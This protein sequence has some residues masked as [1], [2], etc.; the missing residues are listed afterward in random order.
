MKTRLS[1]D[2]Y[3]CLAL[4]LLLFVSY[5]A[6]SVLSHLLM[7]TGGFDL[8]I[9]DEAVRGYAG[10]G[11]PLVALKGVDYNLLGDHFSP[12]LALLAPVYRVFPGPMTL[13]L[14]QAALLAASVLPVTRLAMRTVGRWGGLAIGLAY[15]LSWGLWSALAFDFHEVAF[16]VPL[17]AFAAEA[18]VLGRAVAAV[19]WA[20][21]LL[22]VK[23]D[24]G[25]LVVG[26]GAYLFVVLGK[27]RLG[28]GLATI[29]L[30][31]MALAILV[32]IPLANPEG[33]YT[34]ADTGQ[35]TGDDPLTRLLLPGAKWE[36]VATLLAPTLLL[37]LRSPLCVL[38]VLPLAA[39]F[40]SLNPMFWGTLQH[41]NAVLM[42]VLFLALIDG[43]RR[44]QMRPVRPAVTSAPAAP[45]PPAGAVATLTRPVRNA[46]PVTRRKLDIAL[47]LVPSGALVV[48]V[49]MLPVPSLSSPGSQV[50]NA[51]QA[52]SL[53]PD[54]AAVAAANRLAPQLTDRCTVSLFPYLTPP[55]QAA[56]WIRPTAYWVAT[57]DHPDNFPFPDAQLKRFEEAL[58]SMGYRQVVA[59]GG[60][61]VYRWVGR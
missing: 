44:L 19:C 42:P 31:S 32:L 35:W 21:P 24:Q 20:L 40:W 27:R 3:L 23:E 9:F 7:Q 56:P 61:T 46:E 52:L 5:G 1:A 12:I 50:A 45:V 4:A 14:A 60:V 15:G 48:A 17:A 18:L 57:L 11:K 54:G 58:P 53:I 8:G 43:L 38:L 36:T 59:G 51:K 22:L 29:A 41:Y 55:G 16:A 25:L 13:L 37:A 47:K 34:Y 6:T 28:A 26:I 10:L 33:K 2:R 49:A 39:R 30:L